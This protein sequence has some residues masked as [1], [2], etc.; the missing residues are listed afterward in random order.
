MSTAP[1]MPTST[2]PEQPMIWH[3]TR[4]DAVLDHGRV[5][6]LTEA[7]N[8]AR[9]GA[10]N[11]GDFEIVTPVHFR[12]RTG[13]GFKAEYV[14]RYPMP[15]DVERAMTELAEH[16]RTLGMN[17]TQRDL[18][19]S[20][21]QAALDGNDATAN[22]LLTQLLATPLPKT[23]TTAAAPEVTRRDCDTYSDEDGFCGTWGCGLP[24]ADH[25]TR[26]A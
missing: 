3:S 20:A 24:K 14:G 13:F 19:L 8:W 21:V 5:M 22:D 16:L 26:T 9:S 12:Y 11:S 1:L 10:A 4:S 15:A 7:M 18:I 23:V 2:D 17:L 6:T 25:P